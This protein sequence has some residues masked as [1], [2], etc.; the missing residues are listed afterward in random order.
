MSKLKYILTILFLLTFAGAIA[1]QDIQDDPP[2]ERQKQQRPNLLRELDLTPEQIRQIREINQANR[3]DLRNAQQKIG[4]A[5]RNLD[6]AIYAEKADDANVQIRLRE[7]QDA[8]ADAAR[9][10]AGIE[11]QIRKVLTPEQL[12]RFRE[13]RQNFEEFKNNRQQRRNQFRMRNQLRNKRLNDRQLP[14]QN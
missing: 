10:R 7:F 3:Q 8:Q 1:A 11:F 12:L 14:P 5:R 4:E 9:L 13:I 6:Q 2:P